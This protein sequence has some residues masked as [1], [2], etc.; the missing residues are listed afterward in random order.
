MT[1]LQFGSVWVVVLGLLSGAIRADE[2]KKPE[3]DP[4]KVLIDQLTEVSEPD[5]GYS[6]S[7]AGTAFFPLGRSESQVMLFGQR[8]HSASDAM[9]SLVK[10]GVKAVPALLEHL[11]DDRRTKIE[12]THRGGFG[13]LF[14]LQDKGEKA[15]EE[16]GDAGKRYTV[17][18]GDLCYVAL[19]QI[20]NR[21]YAAVWYQPTAIIFAIS[22]PR[23]KQ[24]R[25]NQVKEWGGLTTEKHQKSLAKDL[26]GEEDL[27]QGASVR[28]AYY[29]PEAFEPLA[30]KQLARATYD[31][32]AASSLIEKELYP[33]MSAKD[34][35]ALVD[36]FVK[37]QGESARDGIRWGLFD[38]LEQQEDDEERRP[39]PNRDP[40]YGARECL[41]DVFGFPPTVK[42]KDR[43]TV[44]PITAG[45]QARFVQTLLYDRGEKLDQAVR[46]IL[47]KT[48]DDF[49]A[50]SCLN[51][52]IGRGYDADIE[53]YL[54]RRL[55]NL[56]GRERDD[57]KKYEAK[58]GWSRLHAAIDLNV[59]EM[60]EAALK[61]KLDVNA[62]AK[63]GRTALHLA[64]A[65]GQAEVVE[66][67]LKAKA[68]PNACGK[69]GRT[70]LHLAAANGMA[71]VVELLLKAKADPNVKNAQG[72]LA[73]QLAAWADHPDTIRRLVAAKSPVLDVFTAA[74]V[75]DTDRL[76]ELLKGNGELVKE[77]N[78]P[79]YT[80][81]HVASREGHE[82]AIRVLIDSGSD[83]NAVGKPGE[84]GPI[85]DGRTPLHLAVLN[86]KSKAAK[87]LLEKG[88]DPNP[89]DKLG[90][91]TPLH[92]AAWSGDVELV[93][94]LLAGKGDREAEDEGGRTPLDLAKQRKH[95]EVVKMLEGAK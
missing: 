22:V 76:G 72:K 47:T 74:T 69:D 2:P 44:A 18:V 89:A 11:S 57:L 61:D 23:S 4:A 70:A 29:Y 52:L 93:R 32:N 14:V 64:A 94:V 53:A 34:R 37:K 33:A 48:D 24:L 56:K 26:D 7:T 50:E 39:Q 49:L 19:G 80:P 58:L 12:L 15:E 62:R 67:L 68:D 54:K 75:G 65:T 77:R 6:P 43:P 73:V 71:E 17:R 63:D 16:F 21:P 41:I 1:R 87:L 25:A 3:T 78:E 8:P 30:L 66:L 59:P 42:S 79:G 9:R 38:A 92:Y 83:V 85:A 46:D 45:A 82:A 88:A 13:G 84:D 20:V 36:E 55:P 35:K 51:R 10:L 40:K 81:L 91:L 5:I 27:R 95:S 90:K 60:I 31:R 86:G 28:L